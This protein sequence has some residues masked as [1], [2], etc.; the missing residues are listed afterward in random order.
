MEYGCDIRLLLGSKLFELPQHSPAFTLA[1]C[2]RLCEPAGYK[3]SLRP[4][5][6]FSFHPLILS[7]F[8]YLFPHLL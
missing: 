4:P 2:G 7:N 6:S 5:A 3:I 1:V 8:S